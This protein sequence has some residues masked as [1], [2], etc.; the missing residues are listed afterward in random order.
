MVTLRDFNTNDIDRLVGILNDDV[1]TEF[2]STKIPSPYTKDDAA[3]WVKEGSQ[4][5]IVKAI[6]YNGALVGCIGVNQ[7]LFEYER[8]GEIGYWL[9]KNYWRKGIT[10]KAIQLISDLVFTNTDIVRI[11]GAVFSGNHASMQLL[12]KSGFSEEAVLKKAIF[13]NGRFYDKH[14]FAKLN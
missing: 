6:S 1:V 7:G 11:F 9:D 10:S 13:K 4:S 8:S 14:V 12:L 2:L 5:N 3:W